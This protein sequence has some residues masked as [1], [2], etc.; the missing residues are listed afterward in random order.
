MIEITLKIDC[1]AF[2]MIHDFVATFY[3]MLM[4]VKTLIP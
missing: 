4:I 1:T 3:Y 2:K